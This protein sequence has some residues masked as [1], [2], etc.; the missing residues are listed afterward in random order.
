MTNTLNKPERHFGFHQRQQHRS[1]RLLLVTA[2]CSQGAL[3]RELRSMRRSLR[4]LNVGRSASH[5]AFSRSAWERGYS[6]KVGNYD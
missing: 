5:I 2:F 4:Y 6:D 3:R 1:Y